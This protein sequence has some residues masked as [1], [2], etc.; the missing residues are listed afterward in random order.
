MVFFVEAK[1][2]TTR[3]LNLQNYLFL[4]P[5]FLINNKKLKPFLYIIKR[6]QNK[7]AVLGQG[8]GKPDRLLFSRRIFI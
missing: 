1:K 5:N 4:N 7:I 3:H 6:F 8:D 2:S